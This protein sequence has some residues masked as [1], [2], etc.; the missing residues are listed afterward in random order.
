[1]AIAPIG[2]LSS[3]S[4]ITSIQPM[5][6]SVQNE[7]DVSDVFA[8]DVTKN[9][10]GINGASPVRYP[11][12]TI[13]TEPVSRQRLIDPTEMLEQKKRTASAYNDIASQFKTNNTGYSRAGIG[14]SYGMAGSRFDAFV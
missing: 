11:N 14:N 8:E 3:Y 7:A 1:M 6:Y 2:G 12:A 5:N 4:P 13:N 9:T 10:D